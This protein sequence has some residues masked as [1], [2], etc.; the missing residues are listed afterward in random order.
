[1]F[2][3]S[4]ILPLMSSFKSLMWKIFCILQ[5]LYA[6]LVRATWGHCHAP[7]SLFFVYYSINTSWVPRLTSPRTLILTN[8]DQRKHENTHTHTHTGSSN[9]VS[10]IIQKEVSSSCSAV[11]RGCPPPVKHDKRAMLH[12][13]RAIWAVTLQ[14]AIPHSKNTPT[15]TAGWQ[16]SKVTHTKWRLWQAQEPVRPMWKL[17]QARFLCENILVQHLRSHSLHCQSNILMP[18][19]DKLKLNTKIQTRLQWDSYSY[20]ETY[21]QKSRFTSWLVLTVDLQLTNH[22]L[23]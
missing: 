20:R 1:M 9:Y 5:L 15:H 23:E 22:F 3:L 6:F 17:C 13:D 4:L 11:Q 18:G 12:P 14:P 7:V 21:I 10:C 19:L 16:L 8:I 2:A